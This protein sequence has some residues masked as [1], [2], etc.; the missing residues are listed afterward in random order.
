[1]NSAQNW[2]VHDHSQHEENLA[3][4][5]EAIKQEDWE[6]AGLIFEEFLKELKTHIVYEEEE[7]FPIYDALVKISHD[8]LRSLRADHDRIISF[9][10]D[11][12]QFIRTRDSENGLECLLRLEVEIS[13]HEEKEEEIFLPMAGYVLDDKFWETKGKPGSSSAFASGRNWDF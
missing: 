7:V 5:K 1:M 13:K 8:P 6:Q 12:Q 3:R 9:L 10:K 4:C 2:F 11:M